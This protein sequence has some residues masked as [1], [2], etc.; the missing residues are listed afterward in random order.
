MIED[1]KKNSVTTVDTVGKFHGCAHLSPLDNYTESVGTPDMDMETDLGILPLNSH[2]IQRK[3]TVLGDK[4]QRKETRSKDSKNILKDCKNIYKESGCPGIYSPSL[5]KSV[6][7]HT[8]V[9]I[10]VDRLMGEIPFC[11]GENK[12]DTREAED[13]NSLTRIKCTRDSEEHNGNSISGFV[14]HRYGDKHI[15][16]PKIICNCKTCPPAFRALAD[17]VTEE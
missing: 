10:I 8:S 3:E 13:N 1:R 2:K 11:R 7:K 15:C 12:I 4:I 16:F 6:S 17:N 9:K 14:T 5:D